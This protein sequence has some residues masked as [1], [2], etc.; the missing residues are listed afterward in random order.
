MTLFGLAGVPA[1]APALAPGEGADTIGLGVV[2]PQELREQLAEIRDALQPLLAEEQAAGSGMGLAEITV[3][4]ALGASGK[5]LFIA[6]GSV[7][8]SIGLVFRRP[9]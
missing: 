4:L 1:T 6:E 2:D 9:S 8:A 3:G 7:E 5:V